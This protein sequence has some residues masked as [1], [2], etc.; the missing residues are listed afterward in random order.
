MGGNEK[1]LS[2]YYAA[3]PC[4]PF[5]FLLRQR[6]MNANE[7]MRLIHAHV[8]RERS[9]QGVRIKFLWSFLEAAFEGLRFANCV[10][11]F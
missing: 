8:H 3:V 11:D 2:R 5:V 1:L 6:Q 9:R 7:L 4:D 10:R